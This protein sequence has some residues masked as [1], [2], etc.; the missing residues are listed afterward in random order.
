MNMLSK[1]SSLVIAARPYLS[2]RN[3]VHINIVVHVDVSSYHVSQD[4]H[5]L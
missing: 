4:T 3:N 1:A 2:N 5:K